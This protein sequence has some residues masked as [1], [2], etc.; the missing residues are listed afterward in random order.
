MT[1]KYFVFHHLGLG[2]HFVMNGFIHFLLLKEKPVEIKMVCKL[3]NE[4]TLRKLY[5]S[6][7]QVTFHFVNDAIDMHPKDDPLRILNMYI[8]QGYQYI[9]FGVHS[10]NE[11]GKDYLTL[12]KSWANCFYL[13]YGLDPKFR[14][15]L[16]KLPSELENSINLAKNV[17]EKVGQRYCILH[18]D[19][20]RD[21]KLEYTKV[22]ALLKEDGLGD[23]PIIYVGK[24]R[25]NYGLIENANNPD[26]KD[27]LVP[28]TMFDYCHLLAFAEV[29]HMMDSSVALLLD[30]LQVRP[31]QKRYMH[32]YAKAGE[33]LS[34]DG[35]FQKEW[36][37]IKE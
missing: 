17:I 36:K 22:K 9:G 7:P 11:R 18:D 5:E 21:F 16:F 33:I 14:W 15:S 26:V 8:G 35:L 28:Q 13:Q 20:S 4:E 12:D 2:D 3:H 24:D 32:E 1:K 23:L 27:I 10:L 37:I 29:C 19:P 31:D 30:N 25:Y 6:T 34:T